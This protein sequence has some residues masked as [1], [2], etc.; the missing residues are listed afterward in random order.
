MAD[1][2]H[3]ARATRR[4]PTTVVDRHLRA[5]GIRGPGGAVNVGAA[6]AALLFMCRMAKPC[7][8]NSSH[9]TMRPTKVSRPAAQ[10]AGLPDRRSVL[11]RAAEKLE[12]TLERLQLGCCT[13]VLR[14]RDLLT[15]ATGLNMAERDRGV[16]CASGRRRAVCGIYRT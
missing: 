9:S 5:H 2:P 7:G 6:L 16:G 3:V 8:S 4:A 13:I 14:L 12:R 10:R 11:L 15:D 1:A